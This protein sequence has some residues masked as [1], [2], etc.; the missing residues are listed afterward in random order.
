[1]TGSPDVVAV[2]EMGPIDYLVIEF[3]DDRQVTGEAFPILLELV[4]RGLVR[5]LDLVFVRKEFDGS[6]AVVELADV[7]KDGTL[8]LPAFEVA[9]SGLLSEDDVAN[10]GEVLVLGSLAGILVYE[11]RWAAPFAVALRSGGAHLVASGR[12]PVRAGEASGGGPSDDME[13]RLAQLRLLGRLRTSGVLTD[14]EYGTEK[15]RILG[16]G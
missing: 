10:A 9:Q 14:A 5:I 12:I 4:D 1:M 7:D 6:V 15:A 16:S 8:G 3:P 11:N 13:V 2:E